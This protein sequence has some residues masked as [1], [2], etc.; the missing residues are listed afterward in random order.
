VTNTTVY[1]QGARRKKLARCQLA[2]DKLEHR[3]VLEDIEEAKLNAQLRRD[4]IDKAKAQLYY[5]TNRVKDFHVS[6]S[7]IELIGRANGRKAPLLFLCSNSMGKELVN[8][9][10]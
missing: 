5:N 3:R 1:W 9:M 6:N 7:Y 8:I 10:Q 4:A 2:A